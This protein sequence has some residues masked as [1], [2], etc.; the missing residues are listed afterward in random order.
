M[1]LLSFDISRFEVDFYFNFLNI[2]LLYYYKCGKLF[3]LF[4]FD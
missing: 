1:V 4:F 3:Y 2:I